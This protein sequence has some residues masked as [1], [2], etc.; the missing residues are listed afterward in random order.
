MGRKIG[1]GTFG[2]VILIHHKATREQF[3]LKLFKPQ[4]LAQGQRSLLRELE[5]LMQAQH[6]GILRLEG[7]S[8]NWSPKHPCPAVIT[9]Y[10]PAGSLEEVVTGQKPL[11]F[12]QKVRVLFG[13]AA[14]MQYLHDQA[15]IVHRDL[16]PA[17]VLLTADL[18]PVVAD[19]GLSKHVSAAQMRQT[20]MAGSPIYMAPELLRDEEYSV[21][22]DV[23][24][25]GILA[26]ELLTTSLAFAAISNPAEVTRQTVAGM[27]PPEG[28]LPPRFR[29]LV[30]RCWDASPA[31]RPLFH[32]VA[33]WI[34]QTANWWEGAD[35]APELQPF[36]QYVTRLGQP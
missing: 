22:V 5:T 35:A 23:Y 6:P 13:V 34:K 31:A 20:A 15:H 21:K 24:A 11:S 1:S 33:D 28:L 25:F 29:D 14:A 7:L 2:S 17:N 8:F 27:R 3:A 9:P 16:K 10:L 19:F 30:T 12:V 26:W 36:K 32:E 4:A 18:E